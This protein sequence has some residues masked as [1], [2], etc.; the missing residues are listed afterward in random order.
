MFY[1]LSHLHK[2]D[3]LNFLGFILFSHLFLLQES[4]K[5]DEEQM[6]AQSLKGEPEKHTNG[7]SNNL[8]CCQF[9]F[10]VFA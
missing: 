7:T 8:R 2:Y 1:F 5:N 10:T 6:D 4:D 3:E 9:E